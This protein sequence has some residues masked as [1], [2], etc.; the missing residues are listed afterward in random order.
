MT[1]AAQLHAIAREERARRKAA[2]A[3]AGQA[4]SDRAQQDD[5]IWS[6]IEQMTG[7]EAGDPVC[8]KRQPHYWTRPERITMARS[9]WKTLIKM[10]DVL[11]R[12]SPADVKRATAMSH[13]YR[14]LR[15]LAWSPMQEERE[16]AAAKMDAA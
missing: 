16:R 12:A 4:L 1:T 14:W 8:S 2:W 15:P 11:D 5:I 7:R 6:N 3:Q 10:E 9:A 13:L